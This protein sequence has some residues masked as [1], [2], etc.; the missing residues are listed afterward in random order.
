MDRQI[1]GQTD[2]ET[3]IQRYQAACAADQNKQANKK[4]QPQNPNGLYCCCA[5]QKKEVYYRLVN[6]QGLSYLILQLL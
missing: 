6:H 1:D 5:Q 4:K 2:G 3:V